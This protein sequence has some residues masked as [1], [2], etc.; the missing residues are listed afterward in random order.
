MATVRR[1]SERSMCIQMRGAFILCICLP[2]TDGE[3]NLRNPICGYMVLGLALCLPFLRPP[4]SRP[5]K[6][7]TDRPMKT[8]ADT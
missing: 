5:L 4:P 7:P 3:V 6:V 2:Q 1:N 8:V